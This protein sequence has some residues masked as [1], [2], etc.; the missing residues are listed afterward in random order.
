MNLMNGKSNSKSDPPLFHSDQILSNYDSG[1]LIS[2]F[3]DL[4]LEFNKKVNIVS[5]ETSLE[6]L[7]RIAA[8]CLVPLELG[9]DIKGRF[10]DIGSGGGFP[11]IMMMLAKPHTEG[12]LIE[13]TGKKAEFLQFVID[14]FH[15]KGK[16]FPDNFVEIALKLEKDSFDFG[17]M[18]YVKMEQKLFNCA[19]SLLKINGKFLHY[20][21]IGPTGTAEMKDFKSDEVRY[22][23][24]D[25]KQI[26]GL[27]I[28][29][30][31]V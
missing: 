22:Y 23:L 10:F 14:K 28:I 17:L 2:S 12:V 5:R 4:V 21:G 1:G 11:G 24:D 25:I 7:R 13:R 19:L 30:K 3:L 26:R 31:I 6:G 9:F 15:L 8:D 20:S 16:V 29:S 18:K 27:T